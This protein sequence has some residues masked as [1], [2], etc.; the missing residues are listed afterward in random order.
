MVGGAQSLEVRLSEV[1]GV[2]EIPLVM[3]K[4]RL[5]YVVIDSG[6]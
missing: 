6:A 4:G 1:Q 5:W 3:L 2:A